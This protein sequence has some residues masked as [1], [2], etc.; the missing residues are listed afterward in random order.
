MTTLL[1]T[2][3]L[4]GQD[5]PLHVFFFRELPKMHSQETSRGGGPRQGHLQGLAADVERINRILA[6]IEPLDGKKT[7]TPYEDA[8]W[9]I[10]FVLDVGRKDGPGNAVYIQDREN[11]REPRLEMYAVGGVRGLVEAVKRAKEKAEEQAEQMRKLEKLDEER[12]RY[13]ATF[14]GIDFSALT[15]PNYWRAVLILDDKS[16]YGSLEKPTLST[17]RN[18]VS[19]NVSKFTGSAGVTL[20]IYPP[21]LVENVNAAIRTVLEEVAVL[22]KVFRSGAWGKAVQRLMAPGADTDREV[23][24]LIAGAAEEVEE[25]EYEVVPDEADTDH[26]TDRAMLEGIA[27]ATE[28]GS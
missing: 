1:P 14:E 19:G 5:I 4:N 27:K 3:P 24:R 12:R 10:G 21:A 20:N 6:A 7:K 11:M 9:S 15:E 18:L 26:D 2:I 22:E 8:V 28:Q 23:P 17:L 13:L 16:Y 25:A